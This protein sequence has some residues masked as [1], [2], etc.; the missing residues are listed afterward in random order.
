M[1]SPMSGTLTTWTVI[2]RLHR[3][4]QRLADSIRAGEIS[5][6]LRMRRRRIP[7]GATVDRC[8][9]MEEAMLLHQSREL[10]AEA[11]AAR[12]LVDD[13]AA[14]GLLDGSDDRVEIERPQAAQV[15]D[16]AVDACF[17]NGGLRHPHHRA[18]GKHRERA[19]RP[20][21]RGR[22]ERYR[23]MTFGDFRE[24]VAGPG[25]EWPLVVS[26]EGPIVDALRLP[27]DDRIVAPDRRDQEY[28]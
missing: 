15:D 28:F 12:G 23:V 9:E 27:N 8:L 25:D 21:N 18:V 17:T 1:P 7:T 20:D 22:F 5:P 10:G 3:P 4:Q 16:L 19:S 24:R 13:H 2:S 26:V 14:A 11:A 6:L